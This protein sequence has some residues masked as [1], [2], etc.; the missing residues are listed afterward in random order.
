MESEKQQILCG[1]H[2]IIVC[3]TIMMKMAPTCQWAA[4]VRHYMAM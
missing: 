2:R 1:V 4:V 3:C